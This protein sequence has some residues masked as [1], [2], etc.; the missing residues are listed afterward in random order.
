[1]VGGE[2]AEKSGVKQTRAL[3]G[4][5]QTASH[6]QILSDS[7]TLRQMKQANP[8]ISSS[9]ISQSS[10]IIIIIINMVVQIKRKRNAI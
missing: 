2:D 10:K 3:A 8:S 1:M 5:N 4:A 7:P 6:S 9:I